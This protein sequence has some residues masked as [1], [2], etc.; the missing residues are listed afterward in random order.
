M[1]FTLPQQIK[2][3][4]LILIC[5]LT[6]GCAV[7]THN[8]TAGVIIDSNNNEPINDALILAIWTRETGLHSSHDG[9]FYIQETLTNNQGVFSLPSWKKFEPPF[10]SSV[11]SPKILIYKKGYGLRVLYNDDAFKRK[12]SINSEWNQKT[13]SLSPLSID[14]NEAVKQEYNDLSSI[15]SSI[16]IQMFK[17]PCLFKK[18]PITMHLLIEENSKNPLVKT[19]GDILRINK[20][21][22]ECQKINKE[23]E[24]S[25]NEQ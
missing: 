18:I 12:K 7:L 1:K 24:V 5:L 16:R 2:F 4:S 3:S 11:R 15:M 10:L 22:E 19:N 13:I 23:L 9:A 6:Y 14:Q 20:I 8:G 17:D 21:H 25:L